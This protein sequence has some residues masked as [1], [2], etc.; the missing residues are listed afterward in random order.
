LTEGFSRCRAS[1]IRV[2]PAVAITV[3]L[4]LPRP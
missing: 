1:V 3:F 2:K 4:Y